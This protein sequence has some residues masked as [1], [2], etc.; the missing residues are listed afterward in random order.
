MAKK[1]RKNPAEQP[2]VERSTTLNE[3]DNELAATVLFEAMYTTDEKAANRYGVGV[4]SIQR[5]RARLATDPILAGVFASKKRLFDA[6][7]ADELPIALRKAVALIGSQCDAISADTDIQK[8][9][10]V[11]HA[12]TG[13]AKTLADVL[14]TNKV[15][16]ARIA[17]ETRPEDGVP[18]QVPPQE[19]E[20][21]LPQ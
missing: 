16:D 7:W 21:Y 11:L 17:Q 10:D 4:R 18:R 15:V 3:L 1:E 13:A 6:R 12:V 14:M 9:P 20:F 5:W 2:V 19:D 8:S